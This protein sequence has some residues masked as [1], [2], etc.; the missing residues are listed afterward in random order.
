MAQAGYHGAANTQEDYL[1]D[2]S[3]GSIQAS[4]ANI[5]MA[6]NASVQTTNGQLSALTANT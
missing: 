2:D 1:D 6:N 3:L 5:Q 4:L